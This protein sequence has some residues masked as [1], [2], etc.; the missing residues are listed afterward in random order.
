MKKTITILSLLGVSLITTN[1]SDATDPLGI[2]DT[3]DAVECATK[4]STLIDDD[5]DDCTEALKLIDE[6][7]KSCNEFISEEDKVT[8]AELRA[9]CEAN[10]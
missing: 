5:G 10:N 3:L 6:L 1:C 7:E 8:I 9:H 4:L 2:L